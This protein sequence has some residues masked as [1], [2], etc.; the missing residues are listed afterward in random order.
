M[1][2]SAQR[3]LTVLNVW[4]KDENDISI[5]QQQIGGRAYVT[6]TVASNISNRKYYSDYSCDKW[7][8]CL[9]VKTK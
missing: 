9:C 7:Y 5:R 3:I 1:R 2:V 8:K 6:A 4:N